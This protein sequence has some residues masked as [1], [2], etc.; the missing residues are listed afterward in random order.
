[1]PALPLILLLLAGSTSA[2]AAGYPVGGLEPSKRPGGAPVISAYE[3]AEQARARLE[4]GVSEPVPESVGKMIEQQEAWYT[5][6][7]RPGMPGPYDLL[8]RHART[9]SGRQQER[10]P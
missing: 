1:M 8:G 7:A 2:A 6:F 4:A 5:P 10:N 9:E 3:P